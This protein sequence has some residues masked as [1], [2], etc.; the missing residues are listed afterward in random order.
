MNTRELSARVEGFIRGHEK[1]MTEDI[2]SLV[3]VRS[4]EGRPAAGAPFGPGPRRALDMALAIAGRLGLATR[5]LEGYIGWAELPGRTAGVVATITHL[6]IVPEG[7]GWDGDPLILRER[8]GWLLGR[9]V[10]DNKGPSVL[11]LWA[12]RCLKE[13]AEEADLPHRYTLRVLLG[14]NEESGMEDVDRYIEREGDPLFCFTPDSDFP[15]CNGEKGVFSG[16]FISGELLGNILD[17]EAGAAGNMVPDAAICLLKNAPEDL[18]GT[19]D[20]LVQPEGERVRLLAKGICGHAAKPEGTCNAIGVLVDYLL[21]KKLCTPAEC[22]YLSLLRKLHA[23]TMGRGLDI[24]CTDEVFGPLTCIGG[25]ISLREGRLVQNINIRYPTVTTG[26][27][28][29]NRLKELA[30]EQGA[31]FRAESVME[32]FFIPAESKPIK[33]LLDTYAEVTGNEALPFT[34]GGG[35]YARHFKNAVSFGPHEPG[36]ALPSFAGPEHAANEGLSLESLRRALKIYIFS[37]LRLME[38]DY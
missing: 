18:A 34:I 23:D 30:Q 9:G 7:E 17:F 2:A 20:V 14:C 19:G 28:L 15:L 21:E 11:C 24:D 29:E 31:E 16:D 35:T 3:A 10:M 22:A 33:A 37:L 5:N 25:M 8:E 1:E 38:L 4:V 6:D 13:L 26:E 12:A 27:E 36:E 32:P